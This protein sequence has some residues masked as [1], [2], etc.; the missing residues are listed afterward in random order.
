MGWVFNATPP[1]AL[2]PEKTRCP[3]YRR[4]GGPQGRSGLVQK[5]SPPPGFDPRTVQPVASRC[6]DYVIPALYTNWYVVKIRENFISTVLRT[7]KLAIHFYL[8]LISY[9][10]VILKLNIV[11][12]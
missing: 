10:N 4:P 2:P 7:Y 9:R 6:T 12:S 8:S 1:A 3:L 11:I 5:I